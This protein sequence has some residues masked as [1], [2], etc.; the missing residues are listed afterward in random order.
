[1]PPGVDL[2]RLHRQDASEFLAAV[3]ASRALHRPWV[4]PPDTLARF[5]AYLE[6]AARPD[7]AAFLLRHRPC[8]RLVGFVT[9]SNLVRGRWRSATLGYAAFVGHD[10]RGLM[11]E[12]LGAVVDLAFSSLGLH[13]VEANIQP[14]NTRSVALVRRL[15]FEREGLSPRFL[16]VDGAWRDHERWARRAD[17]DLVPAP[18]GATSAAGHRRP[19]P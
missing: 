7:R 5:D 1:M 13:R 9:V 3:A 15:G 17:E 8:G 6:R 14:A 18:T 10:G 11:T 19:R 16:W 4:D 12:G 2:A